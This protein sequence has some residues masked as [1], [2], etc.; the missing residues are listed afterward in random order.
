MSDAA[1][2]LSDTSSILISI[3]SIHIAGQPSHSAYSFGYH[4]AEILGALVS[5]LVIWAVTGGLG[6]APALF[7]SVQKCPT[8]KCTALASIFWGGTYWFQLAADLGT[9]RSPLSVAK[10]LAV[11]VGEGSHALVRPGQP[12][13]ALQQRASCP[14]W[15][16]GR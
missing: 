14:C 2:V 8:G 5:V 16:Q 10:M 15:L 13:Q 4:R 9:L 6:I 1:H 7:C 3:A 11:Q 12:S